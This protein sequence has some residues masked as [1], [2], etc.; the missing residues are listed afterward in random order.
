MLARSLLALTAF[1]CAALAAAPL[2]P[3]VVAHS[4]STIF[5]PS[6]H[7]VVRAPSDSEL[8]DDADVFTIIA[9]QAAAAGNGT[10]SSCKDECSASAS[11]LKGCAAV[12]GSGAG[13][14]D[15]TTIVSTLKCVCDAGA[16][17][18]LKTCGK[19]LDLDDEYDQTNELCH[20]YAQNFAG[21]SSASGVCGSGSATASSSSA[22]SSSASQS[23]DDSS[24]STLHL[25]G[26]G[27]AATLVGIAALTL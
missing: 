15:T 20:W 13:D 19:C 10:T 16:L 11:D 14:G 8:S 27:L 23:D 1:G 12:D 6:S 26:A 22:N 9:Q 4:L 21:S 2:T 17:K 18:N 7:L 24:A 5:T 25:A 3:E